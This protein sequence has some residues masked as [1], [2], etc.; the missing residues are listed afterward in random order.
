LKLLIKVKYCCLLFIA[1]E[2]VSCSRAPLENTPPWHP[3]E[4][5]SDLTLEGLVEDGYRLSAVPCGQPI[6]SKTIGDTTISYDLSSID[7]KTYEGKYVRDPLEFEEEEMLIADTNAIDTI[8]KETEVEIQTEPWFKKYVDE[9]PYY[10][11]DPDSI[12]DRYSLI[13]Y[14]GYSIG[15]VNLDSI[16]I[17]QF[18]AN[19]GGRIVQQDWNV[20]KGGQIW[21]FYQNLGLYYRCD[22]RPMEFDETYRESDVY[23]WYFE[24]RTQ[25][26][27][28]DHQ[29][30]EEERIRD[31]KIDAYYERR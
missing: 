10:P 15:L 30:I 26:P 29:R 22:I 17:V 14:K 25:I 19:N 12:S 24:I 8:H 28:L 13:D 1:F 5:R 7:C 3:F 31:A 21:V 4:L 20:T 2:T 27:L 6:F 18:I 11:F 16:A 23:N 9:D